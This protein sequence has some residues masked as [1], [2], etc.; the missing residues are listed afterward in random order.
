MV[1]FTAG[2]G[3]GT[4]LLCYVLAVAYGHVPAWLPMI[5]DCAVRAPEKFPFRFGLVTTSLLLALEN[6]IVYLAAVPRSAIAMLLGLVASL[7]LGIVGVVNEDE[8]SK[9]H[10]GETSPS[11]LLTP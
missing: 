1:H 2:L 5:S 7:C 6:V 4:I 10:S 3:L 8:A 11:H 9:V